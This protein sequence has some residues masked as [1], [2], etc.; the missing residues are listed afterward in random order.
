MRAT[1][2]SLCIREAN[3]LNTAILCFFLLKKEAGV[4][5]RSLQGFVFHVSCLRA[6]AGEHGIERKGGNS[7][8][9]KLRQHI[10][11]VIGQ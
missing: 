1:S 8:D 2:F 11:P 7:G 4:W 5:G 3:V 6:A 10:G 9:Y